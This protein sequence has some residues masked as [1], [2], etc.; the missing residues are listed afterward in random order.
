[1][2]NWVIML[3]I[4]L[5]MPLIMVGLGSYLAKGG[6]DEPNWAFG[7]RTRMAMKNRDTW[8]FAQIYSGRLLRCIGLVCLPLT[9]AVMLLLLFAVESETAEAI[10]ITVLIG[11]QAV[12][13]VAIII[14]VERALRK[15]FDKQGKHKN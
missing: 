13:V 5:I 12:G 9:V 15:H 8:R 10:I 14:P 11:V 2:A 6:T 1:M 4:S 7:Y 3:I